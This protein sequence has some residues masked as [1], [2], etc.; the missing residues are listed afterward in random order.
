MESQGEL[1]HGTCGQVIKMR[2]KPTNYLMAVKVKCELGHGTCGQ[3]IKMRH[4]PTNYLMAVK[5]KCKL[6]H[7]TC[8]QVIKMRH[9]PTNY[10]MAVKVKCELE[11][12]I[13]ALTFP[14]QGHVVILIYLSIKVKI[15]L[16]HGKKYMLETL[17][18]NRPY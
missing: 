4:K 14:V 10:L 3:V 16:G 17:H 7:G 8:G 18:A 1:G 9:K 5:V 15:V 2:H 11:N 6:G 12:D 13:V